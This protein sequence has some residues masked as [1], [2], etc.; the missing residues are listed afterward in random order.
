MED[1]IESF[2]KNHIIDASLIKF[3]D[4]ERGQLIPS[5]GFCFHCRK[6]ISESENSGGPGG[7]HCRDAAQAGIAQ[8]VTE[9]IKESKRN[10]KR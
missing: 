4:K 3:R 8:A 2:R 10:L 9:K 5:L 7:T 1:I 6:A